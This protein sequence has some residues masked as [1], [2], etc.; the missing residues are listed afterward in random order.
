[1]ASSTQWHVM[2]ISQSNPSGY[3]VIESVSNN[4]NEVVLQNLTEEYIQLKQGTSIA[5]ATPIT[6]GLF[7]P[8]K[9]EQDILEINE[10]A[11]K[12]DTAI[13]K[14]ITM[15]DVDLSA[16]PEVHRVF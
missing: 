7:A 11:T 10:K 4:I 1:M 8:L 2:E 3:H 14:V 5:T 13:F 12:E 16:V 9:I 15:E 6:H